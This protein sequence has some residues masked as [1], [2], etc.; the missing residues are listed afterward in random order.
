MTAMLYATCGS[1]TLLSQY[2][3]HKRKFS[4]QVPPKSTKILNKK[5]FFLLLTPP[6]TLSSSGPITADSGG[7]VA[8]QGSLKEVAGNQETG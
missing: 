4:D 3:P 6:Q 8:L 2:F 1:L 7:S 5:K